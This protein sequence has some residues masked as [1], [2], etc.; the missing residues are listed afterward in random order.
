MEAAVVRLE[1]S[2]K[3]DYRSAGKNGFTC[4]VI[5][6]EAM[7]ADTGDMAFFDALAKHQPP[8]DKL[9][10]TYMLRGDEGA[11][12]T[13]PY[14]TGKT[15]DNHWVVTGPH[16]MIVGRIEDASLPSLKC[17]YICSPSG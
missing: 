17:L 8:P 5:G 6:S 4:R 2:G 13:D 15:P 16:I 1:E 9:G 10:L 7:C 11:S 3:N 14:A 12:H